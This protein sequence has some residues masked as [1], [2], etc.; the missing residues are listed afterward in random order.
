MLDFICTHIHTC[1]LWQRIGGC[2][3]A[4]ERVPLI[5]LLHVL[6]FHVFSRCFMSD[7]VPS[8]DLPSPLLSECI[9]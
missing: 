4:I 9:L 1:I 5:N 8:G 2:V 3:T 6:V 7:Y